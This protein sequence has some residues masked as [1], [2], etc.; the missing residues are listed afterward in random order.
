V[1]FAP[2]HEQQ[3][4]SFLPIGSVR[5]C[6]SDLLT[7]EHVPSSALLEQCRIKMPNGTLDM[8]LD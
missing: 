5:D 6:P 3:R 7:W 2:G 1:P 8:I 4:Q